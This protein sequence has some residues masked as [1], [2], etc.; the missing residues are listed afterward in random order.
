MMIMNCFCDM[1]NQQKALSLISSRPGPLPEILIITNLRHAATW[2]WTYGEPEFRLHWMKLCRRDNHYATAPTI[3]KY[4]KRTDVN[5]TNGIKRV[6]YITSLLVFFDKVFKFQ[7]Y[8]RNQCH[9]LLMV[10]IDA[11]K[12]AILNITVLIIIVLS[13]E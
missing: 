10:P 6:P 12:I 1:V 4:I 9:D 5:K 13:A 7:S 2:I 3:N 8:A 11:D